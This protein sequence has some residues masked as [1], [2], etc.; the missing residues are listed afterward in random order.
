ME[1]VTKTNT[2]NG[3]DVNNFFK[4]P[5]YM[6]LA[7]DVKPHEI[8]TKLKEITGVDFSNMTSEE[9]Q[10]AKKATIKHHGKI[11][12]FKIRIFEKGLRVRDFSFFNCEIHKLEDENIIFKFTN[13]GE[14]RNEVIISSKSDIYF[15]KSGFICIDVDGPVYFA[16]GTRRYE[17]RRDDI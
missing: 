3:V 12:K 5:I 4:A 16:D 2:Y 1:K 11:T 6:K 14:E 7:K 15:C 8:I 10:R 9:K 13:L 17:N